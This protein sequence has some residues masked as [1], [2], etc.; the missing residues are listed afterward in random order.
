MNKV[1]YLVMKNSPKAFSTLENLSKEGFNATVV[2]TES[3][4]KAIDYYP[5]E[6]HFFNL[7]QLENMKENA[8]TILCI[9]VLPED[10]LAWAKEII[11]RETDHFSSIRGFMYTQTL[12]DYEGNI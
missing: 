3:L 4:H 9:F 1:L 2:N 7:R 8:E 6:H 10:R 5:E 11:R 12:E